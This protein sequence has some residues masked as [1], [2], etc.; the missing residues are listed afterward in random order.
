M[1]EYLRDRRRW[2]WTFN[3]S[4]AVAF[5]AAGGGLTV[6]KHGNRSVS[7]QCGSADVLEALGVNIDLSPERVEA[8]LEEVGL[9]FLFAPL[10]H[11]AMKHALTPRKEIGI[12]TVFNLLGPLTNPAGANVQVLGLY[13]ADLPQPIAEVLKNLGSQGALVVH[14]EDRCDEISITGKTFVCQL[15]KGEI[16]NY[17]IQPEDFRS[18]K[19]HPGRDPGRDSPRTMQRSFLTSSKELQDPGAMLSF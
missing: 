16:S 19:E 14:G 6:A 5:V 11:P 4:T 10:F 18:E 13:R 2:S 15:K 8:C 9:A 17:E 12:R 7:S 3:I 1:V